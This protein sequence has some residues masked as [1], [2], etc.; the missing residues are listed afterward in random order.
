MHE[1][2]RGVRAQLGSSWLFSRRARAR[3]SPS[4]RYVPIAGY[5]VT[6][7]GSRVLGQVSPVSDHP[8]SHSTATHTV[9]PSR[10]HLRSTLRNQ[11]LGEDGGMHGCTDVDRLTER[12]DEDHSK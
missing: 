4:V 7:Q 9:R 5:H 2:S 10:A 3:V 12:A 8:R 1:T 6:C 11:H